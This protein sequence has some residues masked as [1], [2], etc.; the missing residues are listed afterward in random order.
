MD[1][2][3]ALKVILSSPPPRLPGEFSILPSDLLLPLLVNGGTQYP[4][5]LSDQKIGSEGISDAHQKT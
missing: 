4:L 3:T 5:F 1:Y 2:T